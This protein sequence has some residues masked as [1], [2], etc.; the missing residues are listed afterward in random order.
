MIIYILVSSIHSTQWTRSFSTTK[1][2]LSFS[3]HRL[4]N[5]EES[6]C[7]MIDDSHC[8]IL[9]EFII[10]V[11]YGRFY[12]ILF[13]AV[14]V[15]TS[16]MTRNTSLYVGIKTPNQIKKYENDTRA[17]FTIDHYNSLSNE[18]KCKSFHGRRRRR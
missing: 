8:D 15:S 3:F 4:I 1:T 18:F 17:L 6:L 16:L 2:Y 7:H 10:S 5:K 9:F 11:H 14:N 12:C 13:N